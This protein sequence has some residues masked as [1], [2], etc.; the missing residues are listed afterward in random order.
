M[1]SR[2]VLSTTEAIRLS[3]YQKES[4]R[5]E[6]SSRF[7]WNTGSVR[8]H[9]GLRPG[10]VVVAAL[11]IVRS[12]RLSIGF[13]CGG[14]LIRLVDIGANGKIR[15]R[16]RVGNFSLCGCGRGRHAV[17]ALIFRELSETFVDLLG[18]VVVHFLEVVNGNGNLGA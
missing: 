12:G 3:D 10:L 11:R 7:V 2:L 9:L 13:G 4:A 8:C 6:C 1:E 16:F 5:S 14:I 18:K 15:L 17:L